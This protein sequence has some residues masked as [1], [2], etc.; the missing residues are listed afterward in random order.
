MAA[1]VILVSMGEF[2][3]PKKG[4]FLEFRALSPGVL[5]VSC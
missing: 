1:R 3:K 5:S 2:V 4:Y